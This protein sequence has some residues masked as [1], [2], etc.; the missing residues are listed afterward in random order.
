MVMPTEQR[1]MYFHAASVD[2]S[3]LYRP[4]RNVDTRVVAPTPS[5]TTAMDLAVK[6]SIMTEMK[7]ISSG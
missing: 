1:M 4:T 2:S 7:T 5:Q 6:V 3:L